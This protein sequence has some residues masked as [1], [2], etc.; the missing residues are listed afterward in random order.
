M[1]KIGIITLLSFIFILNSV[2]AYASSFNQTYVRLDSLNANTALSGTICAEPSSAGAGTESKITITFPTDFTINTTA[3]NWTSST[4]N[5]P[6]GATTWPSIG[7]TATS[8]SGKTVTF[9]SGDLTTNT[10]YCFN[11][12]GA[13][14]S[15]GTAGSDKTGTLL[16]KNSSDTTIDSSNYALSIVSNGSINITASVDPQASDLPIAI[17]STTAGSNFPQDTTLNYTI[18]YGSLSTAAVPL[19]IQAEWTQ[20]TVGS[21]PSPSVDILDYVIGSATNAYGSTSPVIDTINRTITWTI[22]SFPGNTINKTVTFS[23]KTNSAYTGSSTVSFSVL[24]RATSGSTTTPDKTVTQT[25]L[26]SASPTS[27]PTPTSASSITPTPIPV[28]LSFIDIS[29]RNLTQSEAQIYVETNNKSIFSIN[30]GTSLKNLSQNIKSAAFK[31]QALIT[32]PNLTANTDYY[33]N[34]TATDENKNSKTSDIFTFKTA[35][36]SDILK[37]DLQT[38]IVASNNIILVSPINKSNINNQQNK[39]VIVIPVSTVFT[40]RFSLTKNVPL[41]VSQLIIR[42]KKVLGFSTTQADASSDYVNLVEV[43]PGVYVG[44]LKSLP[45]PEEYEIYTRLIDFNGNITEQKISDLITTNKL[46]IL[47]KTTDNPIENAR[48]LLY[49]YNSTTKVYE[50]ISPQSLA[51]QNPSF[52]SPNGTVDLVLINGKY[53]AEISALNYEPKTIEFEINQQGGY[54]LVELKR[55]PFDIINLFIYYKDTFMDIISN[56][57]ENLL[58]YTQSNRLFDLFTMSSMLVFIFITLLSF[59]ARTHI[60]IFNLPYFLIYKTKLIFLRD[61]SLIIQGKIMDEADISISKA[62]ISIIDLLT[63]K[64]LFN[65]KTNKLGEFY[66]KK[67]DVSNYKITISKNGFNEKSIQNTNQNNTLLLTLKRTS[68]AVFTLKEIIFI[69]LERIISLFFEVLLIISLIIETFFMY[70]FGFLRIAPFLIITAINIFLLFL[71]LFN[72]IVQ[73]AQTKLVNKLET[74]KKPSHNEP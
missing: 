18:T 74:E 67:P 2:L 65:T 15:T 44:K 39:N 54:P 45:T 34:I 57:R 14:S 43:E 13:S 33:F 27:T 50:L 73:E 10:L 6:V 72:T 5:L 51:I 38:F 3:S 4:T 11:F 56:A 41:K 29:V 55:Q 19:T 70:T 52:S 12:T 46:T 31:T 61:K 1:K 37:V 7:A 8:V 36:T 35:S 24:A 71:F 26:Y 58:F 68:G 64:L 23:L 28:P 20:G 32:L 16:S 66:F 59:S 53:K 48:I 22:S 62:V 69:K 49:L 25:Y 17:E 42:N 47:E 30:Y 21:N 60:S 9:A 40:L 63:N